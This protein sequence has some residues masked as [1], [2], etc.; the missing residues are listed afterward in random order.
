[1]LRKIRGEGKC[2]NAQVRGE[3][4]QEETKAGHV[5]RIPSSTTFVLFGSRF[6]VSWLTERS[7]RCNHDEDFLSMLPSSDFF[8][9]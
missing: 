3:G 9:G 4:V 6:F 1:M 5:R 2:K 8:H 7:A